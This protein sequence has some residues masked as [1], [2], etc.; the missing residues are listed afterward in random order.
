MKKNRKE[1]RELLI[2]KEQLNNIKQIVTN[3]KTANLWSHEAAIRKKLKAMTKMQGENI[4]GYGQVYEEYRELLDDISIRLLD[5]YNKKN[6]TD[7][8]FDKIVRDNLDDY[9]KSGIMTVLVTSHIPKI[10]ADDFDLYIPDKPK[11]DY[12]EARRLKRMVY[13][14]LGETNTGKTYEAIERLKVSD[15]GIYLAPLRILA[16]EIYER[17][18]ESDVA[19]NLV[20]G[21]EEIIIEGAKHQSCTVEKLNIDQNYKVAVID[22]IQ[23]LGD[24]QRGA[25]WTRALLG[26]K[27]PEI[28]VCGALNAKD[29]VEEILQSCEDKYEI[30]EYVRNVPLQI[31][32][33]PF[34]MKEVKEGDA[35]IVFSKKRVLEIAKMFKDNKVE[36]SMIYGD[37]PPEVRKIQYRDFID[38]RNK[39]LVSTDAIGMG[40]NLPIRRII[41]M[42]SK[43]FDGDEI[44]TLTSQEIKQIAGRAGRKGIYEIGYVA[45]TKGQYEFM[46]RNIEKRDDPLIEA[47]VGPGEVLLKI[48]ALPLR[49]KLALWATRE[50]KV[51]LYKKMDIRDYILIL[52]N[53]KRY[54]LEEEVEWRLMRLPFDVH[55]ERVFETF[56]DYVEQYFIRKNEAIYK[57]VEDGKSLEASEIYYQ[58]INL[59]Y[60]FAKNFKIP[61]EEEWVYDERKA[62]SERINQLLISGRFSEL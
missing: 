4:K 36:T 62:V 9:V 14:H 23:M 46:K 50:D 26:L 7:F 2:F 60:S 8:V 55:N 37:L 47:V 56:I 51:P 25:A 49:D 34:D 17:L 53:I 61:F 28:H 10:V 48:K 29:L 11:D 40:V 44:R 39:I 27:C 13:L 54:K 21:E 20:T 31:E 35:L 6:K 3:T 43:K 33:K 32:E 5:D 59:Y 58:K 41:F 52:D 24:N 18:N 45:S 1:V 38:G 22:E 19:C 16:L 57:P 12:I 30:K 42:N 15:N